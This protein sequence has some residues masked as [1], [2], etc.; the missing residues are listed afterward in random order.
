MDLFASSRCRCRSNRSGCRRRLG[1]SGL[2]WSDSLRCR[3]RSNRWRCRR[4]SNPRRRAGRTRGAV[5]V[6][7]GGGGVGFRILAGSLRIIAGARLGQSVVLIGGARSRAGVVAR[8]RGR[9]GGYE[10]VRAA[11][12]RGQHHDAG[13]HRHGEQAGH[14]GDDHGG[15]L[16]SAEAGLAQLID[17]VRPAV[18][19]AEHDFTRSACGGSIIG[20]H[21][22]RRIGSSRTSVRL[23]AVRGCRHRHRRSRRPS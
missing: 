4:F 20:G 7:V 5:G 9:G 18:R 19:P 3:C 8:G 2:R 15:V 23:P 1:W 11:S 14:Q 22:R 16:R 21:A 13:R 10:I 12:L 6:E 17:R